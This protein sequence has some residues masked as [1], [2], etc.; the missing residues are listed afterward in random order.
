MRAPSLS[1]M[2]VHPEGLRLDESLAAL[3]ARGFRS[4]FEPRPGATLRCTACNVVRE[5]HGVQ[6]LARARVEGVSDPADESLI[7]GVRCPNC[8]ALGT[9]VLA[10]GPRANRT[11]A[12]VLEALGRLPPAA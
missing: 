12:Q 2:R 7:L 11:D 3:E 6:V 8:Q 10:Y 4:T 1:S 5:A 9:L